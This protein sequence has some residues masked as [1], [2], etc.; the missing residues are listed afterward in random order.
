M[1]KLTWDQI[2]ARL[3][4]TGIDHG[5][6]YLPNAQGDYNNGVAWNG[7]TSLN[8]E[9]ND[10]FDA[11]YF[12]G[13]KYLDSANVGDYSAK[14][15]AFTYPDEFLAFEGIASL[16]NGLF[17]DDQAS[18]VFGMSY[19]TLVGNDLDGLS[20][21]YQIHLVYNLTAKPDD[22]T[23]QN[24]S[25][26]PE[27]LDFTWTIES[28]PEKASP[29]RPTAHIILDS[30]YL[31]SD[32]LAALEE[33]LYG[34]DAQR[35]VVD[36]LYPPGSGPDVLDGGS[37]SSPGSDILDGNIQEF[38]DEV[39]P[40]LPSLEELIGIVLLWDPRIIVPEPLTGLS[41]LQTGSGDLTQTKIL[42]IYSP[43]PTT[44]LIET[45]VPGIYALPVSSQ[46]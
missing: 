6:L 42:G 44:N 10:T 35:I 31:N 33:I 25:S 41:Q 11:I 34:K 20:Q 4:E 5:V 30:R 32:I 19:R 43:L 28:I 38:T 1:T 45:A 16:G 46:T 7:L 8:E 23:F 12:D 15:S 2:G 22:L 29:Y 40:R 24:G 39:L 18:K 21:G 27:P 26:L 3:Y 9:F 13:V 14:L 17:I 37:P 36:G